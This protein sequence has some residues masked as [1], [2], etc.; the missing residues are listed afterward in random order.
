MD[1]KTGEALGPNQEGEICVR[2]ALVMKGYIGN[3]EATKATIDADGWLH[4]GDIGYYD[5]EG[6]FFVTDR[7]K[8]LIKYNGFQVSP[9]E[10]EHILM[11]HPDVVDAAVAPVPDERSGELPRAFVVRRQG[12]TVTEEE[13]KKLIEGVYH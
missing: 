9:T 11:T 2:G 4:S 7:L 3:E 6:F 12:S 8:E 13:L 1:L 5:E 10:L